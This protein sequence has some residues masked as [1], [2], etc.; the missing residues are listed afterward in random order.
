LIRVE[1]PSGEKYELSHLVTD[2][3]GTLAVDGVLVEGVRERLT[4]L[5]KEIEIIIL[6]SDTHGSV[7]GQ[8]DGLPVEIQIIPTGTG[9][10]DEAVAKEKEL[11]AIG[12]DNVVFLGNGRNDGK[13][14]ATARLSIVILGREGAAR[15]ALE[16]ADMVAA[17]PIDGLDLLLNPTRLRSGL[18]W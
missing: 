10:G 18:R 8:A 14:L 5:A 4:A 3:N 1:L 17:N 11:L 9:P 15:S 2:F 7:E 12:A 13:A 16:N 6:T